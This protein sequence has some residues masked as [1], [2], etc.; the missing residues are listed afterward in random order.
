MHSLLYLNLSSI[1]YISLDKF[2]FLVLV[3]FWNVCVSGFCKNWDSC[4]ISIAVLQWLQKISVLVSFRLNHWFIYSEKS[5][6]NLSKPHLPLEKKS[7][8]CRNCW[9][10]KPCLTHILGQRLTIFGGFSELYRVFRLSSTSYSTH[11]FWLCV[12]GCFYGS[13]CLRLL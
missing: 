7:L 3:Y 12:Q 1:S 10:W 11:C 13:H 8:T 9:R 5:L 6:F 4:K 2:Q